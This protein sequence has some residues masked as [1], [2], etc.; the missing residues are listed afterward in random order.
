MCYAKYQPDSSVSYDE[1]HWKGTCSWNIADEY[2]DKDGFHYMDEDGSTVMTFLDCQANT[3]D[4]QQD[5]I[6]D[7]P[8]SITATK[9]KFKRHNKISTFL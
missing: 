1:Q 7:C 6:A 9:K 3:K 4:S 2:T 8:K 5:N